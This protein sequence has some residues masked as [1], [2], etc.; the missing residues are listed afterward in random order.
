MARIEVSTDINR[1]V[2][3]VFTS[4][5]DAKSWPKWHEKFQETEQTSSGQVDVDTTFKGKIRLWGR[6]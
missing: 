6:T 3:E 2:E 1:P 5:T 4:T